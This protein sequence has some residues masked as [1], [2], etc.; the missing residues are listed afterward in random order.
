MPTCF[1]S[2]MSSM[3]NLIKCNCVENYS[4]KHSLI[5]KFQKVLYQN[6]INL[7]KKPSAFTEG[8]VWIFYFPFA[9]ITRIKL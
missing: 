2:A 8:F 3:K 5:I 6:R 9:G 1:C 4:Q 7:N